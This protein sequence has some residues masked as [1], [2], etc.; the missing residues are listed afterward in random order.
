MSAQRLHFCAHRR[1]SGIF[2]SSIASRVPPDSL[3]ACAIAL[4]G[5]SHIVFQYARIGI[6]IWSVGCSLAGLFAELLLVL[7]L[8]KDGQFVFG[9]HPTETPDVV[10]VCV[11]DFILAVNA[12]VAMTRYLRQID[13]VE[14][15]SDTSWIVHCVAPVYLR[16]RGPVWILLP[17]V[18]DFIEP[19]HVQSRVVR[20]C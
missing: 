3:S 1:L 12:C 5:R 18:D 9:T 10:V 20:H 8:Y 11:C 4:D 14:S 16:E 17:L 13:R 6:D 7:L 15:V 19:D 2:S